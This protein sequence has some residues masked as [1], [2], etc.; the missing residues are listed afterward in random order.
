[1]SFANDKIPPN[2]CRQP[3][4]L[5]VGKHE[6]QYLTNFNRIR[7]VSPANAPLA[8]DMAAN[9]TWLFRAANSQCEEKSGSVRRNT[10]LYKQGKRWNEES[11]RSEVYRCFRIGGET[12]FTSMLYLAK[13]R[14][15][16][17]SYI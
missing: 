12:Q 17:I 3:L 16:D 10:K 15:K 8:V 13:I 7:L 14:K 2:L 11:V 5:C 4:K 9:Q 6:R 1:M